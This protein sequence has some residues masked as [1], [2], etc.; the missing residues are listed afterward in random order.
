MG[1]QLHNDLEVKNFLN[2]CAKIAI[3]NVSQ[4]VLDLLRT[5]I[6]LFTY[7]KHGDNKYYIV[8]TK[9]PTYQF[10]Y[11]FQ[12]KN[13]VETSNSLTKELFYNWEQMNAIPDI[14]LHGSLVPGYDE[15]V[16]EGLADILN[17]IN[18]NGKNSNL[19][20]SVI[21][22]PFWDVTIAK[23]FDNG[24]LNSWFDTELGKFNLK[25]I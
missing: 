15:D 4:K 1:T 21:R 8:G 14:W 23:L 20:I 22:E 24:Q 19:W 18:E 7:G 2:N 11:A 5:N 9:E 10:L 13:M 12:L 6:K 17:T 3:N 16:R 25:R